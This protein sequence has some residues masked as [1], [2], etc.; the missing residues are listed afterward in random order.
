MQLREPRLRPEGDQAP[1]AAVRQCHLP[2]LR[3]KLCPAL[4]LCL[5]HVGDGR[6]PLWAGS[7]S[8]GSQKHGS[9]GILA[10]PVPGVQPGQDGQLSQV[11]GPAVLGWGQTVATGR[12]LMSGGT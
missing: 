12:T 11:G 5:G 1:G 2:G 10:N 8:E 4:L 3:M 7:L 6:E 9:R